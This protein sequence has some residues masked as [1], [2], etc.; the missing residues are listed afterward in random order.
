MVK[1]IS[2]TKFSAR[3]PGELSIKATALLIL[4]AIKRD[5]TIASKIAVFLSAAE[6]NFIFDE[7]KIV[8]EKVQLV[9]TDVFQLATGIDSEHIEDIS[10]VMVDVDCL[11][12]MIKVVGYASKEDHENNNKIVIQF[13]IDLAVEYGFEYTV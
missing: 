11:Q 3:M 4:A 12:I 2:T 6:L 10:L 13:P 8:P 7:T 9:N 5:E 1:T